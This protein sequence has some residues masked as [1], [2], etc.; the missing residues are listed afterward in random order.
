MKEQNPLEQQKTKVDTLK[1]EL[2]GK[3]ERLFDE[4]EKLEDRIDKIRSELEAFE[5]TGLIPNKEK[6]LQSIKE[7]FDIEDREI[8]ITQ[9]GKALEPYLL[10]KI[11]HPEIFEKI[12]REETINNSGNLRLS[13]V[14]YVGFE[15][16]TAH[17]H[18]APASEL[19]KER[20][21]E[22][23]K[24]EIIKGLIELAKVLKLKENIKE[25]WAISW[26]VAKTPLA[27][28]RLGFTVV[29]EISEEEKGENFLGEKRP[30]AEAF[31]T[32]E[33]LLTKYGTKQD[34]KS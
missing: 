34:A 21:V 29:G 9:L 7:C 25:I 26:I 22:N 14:L 2:R 13:E 12:N 20:G 3:F 15:N 11:T 19:I 8:F 30:V 23:F 31:M 17:I 6:I 24:Q 1:M 5:K 18:L 27:F 28:K 16:N 33:E 32:R 10:L 4:K